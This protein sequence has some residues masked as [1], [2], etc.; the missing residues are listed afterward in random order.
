MKTITV[1]LI[2]LSGSMRDKIDKAKRMLKEELIPT[3]D[4]S[5]KI[6]VS[7][8]WSIKKQP[9]INIDYSISITNNEQ[10]EKTVNN[11]NYK[12]AG[13]PIAAAIKNTVQSLSEYRAF[14]KRIVLVT[15]GQETDGGDYELESQN[16]RKDGIEC[17]IHV[18]GINLDQK[19][20]EKAKKISSLSGGSFSTVALAS[21]LPYNQVVVKDSLANFRTSI[22]SIT[23]ESLINKTQSPTKTNNEEKVKVTE[24]E[25]DTELKTQKEKNSNNIESQVAN[26]TKTLN[27]LNNKLDEITKLIKSSITD[28]EEKVIIRE[29]KELN[30]KVGRVSEEYI[31]N[32][33]KEKYGERVKWLNQKEETY[34]NHDF[35]IIDIDDTIEYYIES[36]GTVSKE[37]HFL[38]TKDEWILF[39]NNTKNYQ[40]YFVKD[41]LSNPTI[42]KIDN[43]LDWILKGKIV[44][45]SLSNIKLKSE[46][47]IMTILE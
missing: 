13:T 34:S 6:G 20:Q 28:E 3:I 35:E 27:L 11:L 37:N 9:V 1:L 23:K 38:I 22:N 12:Q 36:K 43:L 18:I 42:I 41:A 39:L 40:L 19:A 30:D 29:N 17:E 31:F 14:N 46:R 8:F 21:K 45:Y 25:L 4:F 2:D 26:N 10:I 44:P 32:K 5:D 24:K 15:D 47:I 33:L 7:S 16:A